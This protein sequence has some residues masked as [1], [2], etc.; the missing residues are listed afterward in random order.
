M[1]SGAFARKHIRILICLSFACFC[2]IFSA[3]I[4]DGSTQALAQ[5]PELNNIIA[6]VPGKHTLLPFKLSPLPLGSIKPTGWLKDQMQLMADG[7]AGHEYDFYDYVIHS[8]WLGGDKEY[9]A[10]N[11]GFPY[12]FNG[13]VPLAYG[14]ND[15]R[16]KRQVHTA[17]QH[18]IDHQ[19]DDGWLGP[20]ED[21]DRLLWARFPL[22]LGLIQL[23]EANTTWFEPIVESLH[24]F[25]SLLNAL[26]IDDGLTYVRQSAGDWRFSI[27]TWGR[28]RNADMIITLQ[29]LYEHYPSNRSAMIL[30]NMRFLHDYGLKWENWYAQDAYFG[31]GMHRDLYSLPE[32]DTLPYYHYQHGVNV[33]QGGCKRCL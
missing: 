2:Y 23:A 4:I 24:K 33:A 16:L 28:V 14:L 9:S 19:A 31:R 10:L 1:V 29:W 5:F 11:E 27:F 15:D 17:A 7:L 21:S 20:E 12:W 6:A 3:Q 32:N 22:C 30:D 13:L 25:N 18:V 8:K 26:L